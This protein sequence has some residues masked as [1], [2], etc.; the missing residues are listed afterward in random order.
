MKKKISIIIPVFNGENRLPLCLDSIKKQDFPSEQLEIIIVDDD[1][2]DKT[3]EIAKKYGCKVIR[4]GAHNPERGKSIGIEN[5][6]SEY[7]FFIDDD[8]I[9]PSKHMLSKL[10]K[11]V[12]NENC[13]GGQV[14][15]FKYSKYSSIPDRYMALFGCGDPAVFYLKKRDHMQTF[16]TKWNLGGKIVK[17]NEDFFKIKFDLETL[18][19]IGSQGFLIKREFI[20]KIKW[21]PMFFHID[22][23]ADLI[24]QGYTDYI[25]LKQS[26]IHNHSKNL[27]DFISKIRRNSNQ[28]QSSVGD[29]RTYSYN[30]T[31]PRLIKLGLTLGTVII[32]LIDSI[33][34]FIK[35]PTLVWFIH[36]Y[37]SFVVA[38]EYTLS[39]IKNKKMID[40]IK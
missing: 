31:G 9:I 27:K 26:V 24:R 25:I 11:A 14:A 34:G 6:D 18:P 17:E 21:S 3:V 2:T 20:E 32:P 37:V 35:I 22:A 29:E 16:E 39:V 10:Y 5:S 38:V 19:T 23:N 13:I 8:N 15:K 36:P 7:L 40:K 30:L 1:S 33:K 12:E 4:N 28:L